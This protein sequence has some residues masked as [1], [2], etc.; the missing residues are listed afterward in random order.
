VKVGTLWAAVSGPAAATTAA[1]IL[2]ATAATILNTR[3][4]RIGSSRWQF[5]GDDRTDEVVVSADYCQL[6]GK[7][8]RNAAA[9][10]DNREGECAHQDEANACY[11]RAF[12]MIAS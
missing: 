9:A 11:C 6:C 2:T 1:T 8:K 7:A 10:A 12:A 4:K 3:A 5:F